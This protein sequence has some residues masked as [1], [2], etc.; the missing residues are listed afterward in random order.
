MPVPFFWKL[1]MCRRCPGREWG[2][3]NVQYAEVNLSS[4]H[5]CN[6]C[7]ARTVGE[8]QRQQNGS[9]KMRQM[10][11]NACWSRADPGGCTGHSG[12][13]CT[14]GTWRYML[15]FLMTT[16]VTIA[17]PHSTTTINPISSHKRAPP[18]W[19]LKDY[20]H[21]TYENTG[22]EAKK[23][24]KDQAITESSVDGLVPSL[25][26]QSCFHPSQKI[27]L[28]SSSFWLKQTSARI[29]YKMV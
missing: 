27:G 19:K 26:F 28:L 13:Q 25:G 3:L 18:S 11:G 14:Q 4:R 22:S 24:I 9:R 16:A 15:S 2:W 8:S 10:E 21:F 29:S 23:L 20:L 17:R 5:H 6:S 1:A 7:C 12:T